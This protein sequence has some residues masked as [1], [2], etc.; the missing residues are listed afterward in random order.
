MNPIAERMYAKRSADANTPVRAGVGVV[1]RDY[2]GWVLLEKRSDC[3]L[4]GL[5]GGRIDPGESVRE[6]VIREVQ[7]ETGLTVKIGCLVGVYSNP[8]DH[9]VTYPDNGDVV[10][11]VDIIVEATV[12]TGEL[13]RSEESEATQF[14][15]PADLPM[16]LV[17]LS[18]EPI[19][20][21]IAGRMGQIC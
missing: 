9:I 16:D 11:I 13:R 19:A 21:A 10:Q 12:E 2:R 7:E 20:D 1:I 5:P 8:S 14:F 17:P 18:R 3:G 15:D 6:T 4:W